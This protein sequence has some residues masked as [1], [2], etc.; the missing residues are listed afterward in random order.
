V[1][2]YFIG[3]SS[4]FLLGQ[5]TTPAGLQALRLEAL[6]AKITDVG[7][8]HRHDKAQTPYFGGNMSQ[9]TAQELAEQLDVGAAQVG[10]WASQFEIP[11]AKAGKRWVYAEEAREV[12]TLIKTL[13][14][15]DCGQQTITRHI[16]SRPTAAPRSVWT[17]GTQLSIFDF[18]PVESAGAK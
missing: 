17:H 18:L 11:R 7:Q 6:R 2:K 12:L 3:E 4:S 16:H 9:Y 13:K 5:Y 1:L 14:G 15:Q 8:D 10:L